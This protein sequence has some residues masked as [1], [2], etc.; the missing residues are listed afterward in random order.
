MN[1][2][3]KKLLS[4]ISDISGEIKGAFNIREDGGCAGRQS[5]ENVDIIPKVGQPG[6]DIII[7]PGTHETVYIPA[8]VTKSNV[9]DLVYNDFYVGENSDVVIVAGCGVHVDGEEDSQHNGIHR[10]FLE[11]GARLV[12]CGIEP[13][14]KLESENAIY[15]QADLTN[16]DQAQNVVDKAVEAFGQ[17][18]KLVCCAGV[19][20]IG[21]LENTEYNTFMRELS[22][23]LGGVFNMCKAAVKELVKSQD[24][25]IVTI[26]SDAH[27][28]DGVGK[29]CEQ[30][31]QLLAEAG[32]R[33]LATY[34]KRK[35]VFHTL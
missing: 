1:D 17:V 10:F 12:G 14:M 29:G 31:C 34:E 7:K 20:F 26:G 32:F 5:T 35:P 25:S 3:T 22:I 21:S 18:D 19:T 4:M 6:I 23:N 33:Y 11:E 9:D 24:P 2:I 30:A 16:P 15:V 28:T 8:C 13:A 27:T